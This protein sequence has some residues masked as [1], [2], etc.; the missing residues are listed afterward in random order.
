MGIK[1]DNDYTKQWLARKG[2][3]KVFGK[4]VDSRER[5]T[6]PQAIDWFDKVWKSSLQQ[7]VEQ[8]SP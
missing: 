5:L 8:A 3:A 6:D 1:F 7:A 4:D 2:P